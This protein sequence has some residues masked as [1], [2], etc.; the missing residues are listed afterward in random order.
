MQSSR[1]GEIREEWKLL[2]WCNL[3]VCQQEM[4][5][6]LLQ[7]NPLRL[8]L[9]EWKLWPKQKVYTHHSAT[10]QQQGKERKILKIKRTE[11][12]DWKRTFVKMSYQESDQ[13]FHLVGTRHK[14]GLN[15]W[16]KHQNLQI[17]KWSID[18]LLFI[19]QFV[20]LISVNMIDTLS[21]I[22][23]NKMKL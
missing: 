17:V 6:S 21:I 16:K 11:F 7:W 19:K 3:K 1:W 23:L 22:W 5:L 8:N 2:N 14:T 13:Y 4:V 12:Q 9:M 18:N 15:I 20:T 10:L